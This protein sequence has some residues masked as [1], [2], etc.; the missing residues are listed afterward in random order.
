MQAHKHHHHPGHHGS[1]REGATMGSAGSHT[2]REMDVSSGSEHE[3]HHRK[4]KKHL[5]EEQMEAAMAAKG[6]SKAREWLE[7]GFGRFKH[8]SPVGHGL[9]STYSYS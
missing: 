4:H 6:A 7:S 2:E 5:T 3:A 1:D 9:C 8:V